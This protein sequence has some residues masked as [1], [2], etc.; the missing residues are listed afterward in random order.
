LWSL[1]GADET[2]RIP[3]RERRKPA[4]FSRNDLCGGFQIARAP[5]AMARKFK[6]ILLAKI[7]GLYTVRAHRIALVQ[8][9]SMAGKNP[10][11]NVRPRLI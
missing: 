10:S 7:S 9:R 6:G 4:P 3:D 2:T 1:S 8:T 5:A 11:E